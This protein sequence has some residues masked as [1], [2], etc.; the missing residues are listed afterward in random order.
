MENHNTSKTENFALSVTIKGLIIGGLTLLLLIPSLMI[1]GLI[2]ERKE[3][4]E[5]A[6]AKINTKW[7]QAQT[8]CGPI[9]TIPY[10]TTDADYNEKQ[11]MVHNEVNFTPDVLKIDT[12]LFPKE[13]YYGIYKTILYESEINI[14]G[15]FSHIDL[16]AITDGAV[17]LKNAHI[18]LGL[19]DL[20]GITE[21]IELT[22]NGKRYMA[23]VT[24]ERN[25]L[26]KVLVVALNDVELL[27]S[28]E[29]ITFSSKIYL[30]GSSNISFI[31]VGKTTT[32]EVSGAWTSP[33]FIGSFSP[34]SSIDDKSFTAKWN[35]LRF[36]RNIPD[37]WKN[38]NVASFD[39]SSFGVNLVETAD[40]Y[41]QNMRSAKYAIMFIVLTFVVFF[42]VEILTH[43]KIH[44]IQY[45]LVGI[46]LVLFYSLL[47]SLSEQ[48][49]FVLAYLIASV[50][51]IGLI[52]VYAH[53]IFKNVMQ[54]GLLAIVLIG[55][56]TF[57]Y[58]VLQLEDRALMIGSVG[59]FVIL[60]I[61]MYISRKI[62]WY[63][64][65]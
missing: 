58:V 59:L 10:T 44:P 7:S 26:G 49:S 2:F 35:I 42:F 19:S 30:K 17:D 20:K 39:D 54:T 45:L 6:I 21:N 12:K 34:D 14:S 25:N 61:I 15:E 62:S 52:I 41:Q 22:I 37:M 8:L 40:H 50:A 11:R 63:K 56:Y 46:A 33:G 18:K 57:L 32:V 13:R 65:E 1:Q 23:D 27:K 3:R 31:P 43:K 5:E 28:G 64:A 4:S 60:A 38:D 29:K 36:N 53:S 16:E 51:T 48:L 47:L 55:L 9:L 24:G